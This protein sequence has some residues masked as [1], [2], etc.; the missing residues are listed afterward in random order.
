MKRTLAFV[1]LD[2]AVYAESV[3]SLA[4]FAGL[5]PVVQSLLSAPL[6]WRYDRFCTKP[7]A[8]LSPSSSL[9]RFVSG[10]PNSEQRRQEADVILFWMEQWPFWLLLVVSSVSVK[11]LRNGRL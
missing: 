2:S 3:G 10:Q 4:G 1:G 11:Q 5:V 7:P 6:R 9:F 8:R